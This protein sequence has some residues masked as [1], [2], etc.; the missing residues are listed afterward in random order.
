MKFRTRQSE[1]EERNSQLS[2]ILEFMQK[3]KIRK[4]QQKTNI[5]S[6]EKVYPKFFI[7]FK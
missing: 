6:A 1:L 5:E 2:K 4:D 3:N 7:N